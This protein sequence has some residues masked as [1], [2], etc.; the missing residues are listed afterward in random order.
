MNVDCLYNEYIDQLF[1]PAEFQVLTF[2]N[3]AGEA[4]PA[5]VTDADPQILKGTGDMVTA[6][7][8][9]DR[10]EQNIKFVTIQTQSTFPSSSR[11]I[12]TSTM[13]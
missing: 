4:L 7:E 11:M 6:T 5:T 8:A 2:H 9:A 10:R 3:A 13:W 1:Y 12:K